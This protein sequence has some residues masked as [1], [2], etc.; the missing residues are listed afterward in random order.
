LPLPRGVVL[1]IL[2]WLGAVL[3]CL[4]FAGIAGSS[5]AREVHIVDIMQRTGEWILPIRNGLVPSKPPLTHWLSLP[6]ALVFGSAEPGMVRLVSLLASGLMLVGIALL[7]AQMATAHRVNLTDEQQVE[8][9]Y[10]WRS[11]LITLSSYH[12]IRLAIDARVDMVFTACIT[13]SL[14]GGLSVINFGALEG[15]PRRK[16]LHIFFLGAA[17]AILA[18][19]PLGIVLPVILIGSFAISVIGVRTTLRVY[20]RPDWS[21]LWLILPLSWYFSAA[22]RGGQVFIERQLFFENIDRIL[23]AKEINNEIWWFYFPS[24]LH[25]FFPW[26]IL[27]LATIS[28][29]AVRWY[30]NRSYYTDFRVQSFYR[31]GWGLVV[32]LISGI[33]FFSVAAGK[34]HSYLLPLVPFVAVYLALYGSIGLGF[35]AMICKKRSVGLTVTQI[36]DKIFCAWWLPVVIFLV[37]LEVIKWLNLTKYPNLVKYL[38]EYIPRFQIFLV[39]TT[40]LSCWLLWRMSV[41]LPLHIDIKKRVYGVVAWSVVLSWTLIF[42]TGCKAALKPHR[43]AAQAINELVPINADLE[44]VRRRNDEYLDPVLYYLRREVRLISPERAILECSE[45]YKSDKFLILESSV[46]YDAKFAE[47][48]PLAEI[49]DEGRKGKDQFTG[50]KGIVLVSCARE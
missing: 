50:E 2:I 48:V 36:L 42:I 37:T 45:G 41:T 27:L 30:R 49:V 17:L 32:S 24:F 47:I 15:Y 12:F 38:M 40:S 14:Y 9:R 3:P 33:A 39:V 19:G 4:F 7:T 16:Y 11:I 18:K 13:W 10:I 21:W 23:G 31:A 46:F 26:S 20:L 25:G 43:A 44:A 5:E 35:L 29:L 6:F 22:Y 1:I 34:R 28:C 8:K